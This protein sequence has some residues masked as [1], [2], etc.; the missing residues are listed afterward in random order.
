[1]QEAAGYRCLISHRAG[2]EP[3]LEG[4]VA[5][6]LVQLDGDVI[7]VDAGRATA[8][9]ELAQDATQRRHQS[10]RHRIGRAYAASQ[11]LD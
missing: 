9:T 7:N 3:R 4:V 8:R 6:E 10:R 11:T 1:M 2:R 5:G